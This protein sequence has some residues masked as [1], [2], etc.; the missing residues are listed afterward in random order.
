[1]LS[2]LKNAGTKPGSIALNEALNILIVEDES[3]IMLDLSLSLESE[4]FHVKGEA[5]T[6]AEGFRLAQVC[7][8]DV[9]VLDIDV[10]S[11]KIWPLAR[12]LQEIGVTFVFV[13]A[14]LHH[15][16]LCEE[17]ASSPRLEKPASET[18]LTAA[19]RLAAA[20]RHAK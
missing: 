9:A 4:G 13:S 7:E 18:E 14:N 15:P 8:P 20:Q 12:F 11:E 2:P 17:F 19:V 5:L 16:E 1:M 3:L 6:L 10:G